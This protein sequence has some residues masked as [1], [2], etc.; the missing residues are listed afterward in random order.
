[1]YDLN[2][3]CVHLCMSSQGS[4]TT[5]Y[6]RTLKEYCTRLHYFSLIILTIFLGSPLSNQTYFNL[7][8][9]R[10][11]IYIYALILIFHE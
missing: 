2:F 9:F 6:V 8:Y 1:M 5:I 11:F 10:L 3:N 4:T 7:F